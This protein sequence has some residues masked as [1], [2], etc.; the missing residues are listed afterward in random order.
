MSSGSARVRSTSMVCGRQRSL[1]RNRLRSRDEPEGR[2]A[3]ERARC[4]SVI[5]SAAA[6]DS[7]RSDAFATSIPVRSVDHRLKIQ[8]RFET[9]LRDLRLVGRVG[10]I[11]PGVLHDHPLNDRRRDRV[12]IAE[13][14]VGAER[15]VAARD[16]RESP[17]ILVLAFAGEDSTDAVSRIARG[18]TRRSA[19]RA[20]PRRRRQHWSRSSTEGPIWR[21]ANLSVASS[22]FIPAVIDTARRRA[23]PP[24]QSGAI[25]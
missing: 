7:S 8:Q 14:D 12:V 25:R 11:P 10:R 23:G 16:S 19:R 15:L 20:M 24:N 2:A 17:Q 5:A 18:T 1:T 6:V 22:R 3:P 9:S 4:S 21:R 13:T